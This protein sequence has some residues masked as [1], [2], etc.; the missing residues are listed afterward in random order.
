MALRR[1]DRCNVTSFES[2]RSRQLP[3]EDHSVDFD[4]GLRIG[5]GFGK[6][7]RVASDRE[8]EDFVCILRRAHIDTLEDRA[9]G[10]LLSLNEYLLIECRRSRPNVR[11]RA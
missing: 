6:C 8:L 11:Q 3:P 2:N 10:I 9:R 4:A 1:D 5:L 7:P